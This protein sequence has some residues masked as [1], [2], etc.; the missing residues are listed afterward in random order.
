MEPAALEPHRFDAFYYAPQLMEV[1]AR[2]Q[3]LAAT[4]EIEDHPGSDFLLRT[5]MPVAERRELAEDRTPLKYI[6]IGDVT[7]YGLIVSWLDGTIDEFP[8]RG[9]YR[10]RT[11]DVL[12]AINNSSRG[13][14][15]LVPERFDGAICTSGFL[16]IRPRTAEEGYLLWYTLR[17]ELCRHQMY[18]LAQTAS[19]PELKLRAWRD[20]FHVPLPTGTAAATAIAESICFQEHLAALLDADGV[21]LPSPP[22][23]PATRG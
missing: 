15:V 23:Q 18:Y 9:Q 7:P 12:V 16:V 5:K 14:V 11:G 13:T 19:Q 3:E 2:I 20:D 4:G 21:R 10:I 22:T 17:S 6:E 1:R 8:S